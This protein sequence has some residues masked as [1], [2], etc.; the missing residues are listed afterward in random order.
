MGVYK[1]APPQWICQI[2]RFAITKKRFSCAHKSQIERAVTILI[3]LIMPPLMTEDIYDDCPVI[4]NSISCEI[5]P[6]KQ[7]NVRFSHR[8]KMRRVRPVSSFSKKEIESTWYS[9]KEI[10]AIRKTAEKTVRLLTN[11]PKEVSQQ[12]ELCADGL[13]SIPLMRSRR[14]VINQAREA[15]LVEQEFQQLRASQ[16]HNDEVLADIYLMCTR[17]SQLEALERAH[18]PST[19]W[20][21]RRPRSVNGECQGPISC[22]TVD[23]CDASR[24]G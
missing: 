17:Q 18:S 8:V 10:R 3:S 9:Q 22:C 6:R 15:V 19:V 20:C 11:A 24:V 16:C 23:S 14:S 7:R 4:V 13:L 2:F 21:E 12:K 5:K 1:S